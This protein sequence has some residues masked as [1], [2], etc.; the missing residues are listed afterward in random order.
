MNPFRGN[1]Q[2]ATDGERERDKSCF[3]LDPTHPRKRKGGEERQMMM[4]REGKQKP[5]TKGGKA[6]SLPP[7]GGGG[8]G[9][10][11]A[12]GISVVR[13][14]DCDCGGGGGGSGKDRG[15]HDALIITN[16][17]PPLPSIHSSPFR[18]AGDSTRSFGKEFVP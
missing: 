8:G 16:H 13:G 7:N 11:S 3:H 17:P 6:M 10:S 5:K 15:K 12:R 18:V 9:I 1:L 14:G 4:T 2:A